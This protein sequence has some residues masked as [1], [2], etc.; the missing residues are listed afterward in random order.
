MRPSSSTSSGWAADGLLGPLFGD[1]AVQARI[2]DDAIVVAM[3]AVEGALA[4]AAADAGVVPLDAAAAIAAAAS[5]LDVEVEWLGLAA[6]SAGNPVPALVR[7]LTQAVP[8][9]HRAW[10]HHGATSQ[11]VWDTALV[12]VVRAACDVIGGRT[13]GAALAAAELAASHRDTIMVGRTL[14]QH[15]MPTT[16]GLRA[17]GWADALLTASIEQRRAA[18][19]LPVQLGGAVGTLAAY[20]EHG[21]AVRAALADRLGLPGGDRPLSW[22]TDRSPWLGL[23]AGLG[24][25]AAACGKVA[26]DIRG[27][28]T[29][30]IGELRIAAAGSGGSSA[31]PHKHNPVAAILAGADVVR[32]PGLVAT[33]QAASV[34][35]HERADGSW[36]AEWQPLRE[37]VSVVGGATARTADAVAGIEVDVD[38]MRH[39]LEV[40][41]G[42]VMTES[43]AGRLAEQLGRQAAHDLVA[44]VAERAGAEHVPFRAVLLADPDVT[45]HLDAAAIDAALDPE[46]WLGTAGPSV[47][48]VV[49]RVR[50]ALR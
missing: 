36:H 11:D 30:D 20:G 23:A 42:L 37:L 5:D 31:M 6:R 8:D 24:Q 29:T 10:V 27:L 39:N 47:D 32:V 2:D 43:V 34:H 35:E 50:E 7:M 13:D 46:S 4:L 28:A 38:R 9:R 19:R 48:A 12:L 49:R 26:L 22:H 45:R 16:F 21:L 18:Q 17:A 44:G 3:L 41:D 33:L 25:L 15:A 40:T 14:G 1:R